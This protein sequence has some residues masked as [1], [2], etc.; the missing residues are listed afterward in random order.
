MACYNDIA[1]QDG[2]ITDMETCESNCVP[3]SAEILA[4]PVR[5]LTVNQ[6]TGWRDILSAYVSV[7]SPPRYGEVHCSQIRYLGV[8]AIPAMTGLLEHTSSYSEK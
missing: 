1:P 3:F 8:K 7:K 2:W 6:F 5:S 4:I